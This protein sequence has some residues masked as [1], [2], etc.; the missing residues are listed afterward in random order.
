M[1]C[2]DKLTTLPDNNARR[3]NGLLTSKNVS[4]L[5]LRFVFFQS[6]LTGK[7]VHSPIELVRGPPFKVTNGR[8]K[9]VSFHM[10]LQSTMLVFC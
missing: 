1:V 5:F 8:F 9:E 10:I 7:N 6:E 2:D 4:K 3:A